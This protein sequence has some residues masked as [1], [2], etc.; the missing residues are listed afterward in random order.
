[1]VDVIGIG[2][3]NYDYMFHCKK[4]DSKKGSAD[5]SDEHLGKLRKETEKAITELSR[6]DKNYSTQV[7]G[8]AYLALKA[9]NAIDHGI[10]LAYVGVCGNTNEF[11]KDYVNSWNRDKEFGFFN[12]EWF[13]EID[14]NATKDD[15]HLMGQAVAVLH[16]HVRSD[17]GIA[18]AANKRIIEFICKKEKNENICFS[19]FLAQAKWIHVSSFAVFEHFEIISNYILE[20]KKKNRF[21]RV[22]LDP[23]SE[24][25]KN[26][27]EE[28]QKYVNIYDYVFLTK[29]EA[30]NLII[31]RD[32]PR[33]D[34]YKILASYFG[35][36][37]LW[38]T[39]LL[40]IKHKNKH[41]LIDF[42]NGVPFI[43]YHTRLF[44]RRIKNDTGAG[45]CLAGGFIAGMLTDK[46]L[47]QQ[48]APISLGAV[49]AKARMSA[50]PT[51]DP[52]QKISY[53]S[54][55]FVERKWKNGSL[56][57]QQRIGVIWSRIADKI[58]MIIVGV[59]ISIIAGF[60]AGIL[61]F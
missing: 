23:G 19:D 28:M 55:K 45:D 29:K 8:S 4:V 59:V 49:A 22:S 54:R 61:P 31:N 40:I 57:R 46:M 27:R 52:F 11:D 21:L 48:P 26:R 32:L 36:D 44:G 39:K 35:N 60:V 37:A 9:I 20:A 24:Y 2:A 53:E 30:D 10:P 41:E 56:N 12:K 17:I 25:T 13:F 47:S 5:D 50:E 1:M 43:Y 6:T 38:N 33:K 34:K 42:V 18:S 58:G 3:I 7:G 15:N 16:N 14:E 51:E